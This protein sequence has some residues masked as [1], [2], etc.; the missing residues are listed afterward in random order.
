MANQLQRDT[1]ERTIVVNRVKLIE[2]LK[3]NKEKHIKEYDKAFSGYK[4]QALEK[5]SKEY[6]SAKQ[7]LVKAYEK[8]MDKIGG[9]TDE[10]I[11]RQSGHITL[12]DGIYIDMPVPKNYSE[13]YD[14][15]I[16][17]MVMDVRDHIELKFSEFKCFI[18]DKWNWKADFEN[19]SKMYTK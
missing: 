6:E 8:T 19:I 11:K 7:K 18:Q 9:L 14:D 10:E 3:E 16:A 13:A 12:V 17:M 5:I 4:E 1:Q 2:I 15:A